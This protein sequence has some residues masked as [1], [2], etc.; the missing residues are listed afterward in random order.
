VSRVLITGANGHLGANTVRA[1]LNH[2]HEVVA[3][4]RPS[5]DVRGLAGL[6][7]RYAYG[8]VLDR[9]SLV[10]AASGAQAIIHS[11]A[12]FTYWSQDPDAVVRTGVTGIENVF[13]AAV[14]NGVSRVIYTSSTYA[15]GF[16]DD[17]D[18]PRGVDQWNEDAHSLYAISK[19]RAERAAWRLSDESGIPLISLCP[20]GMWGPYDYRITPAMRWIK[21]LVEGWLPVI[22]TAGS[23]VDVR[24]AA[25]IHARALSMGQPGQRYAIVASDL[26]HT[27]IASIVHELTGVRN[28]HLELGK[29]LTLL[30]AGLL[31]VAGRLTG[32][33]P[34]ATRGFVEEAYKRGLVADGRLANETFSVEPR[35]I[36]QS[37][38]DSI[39]WLMHIDA[40]WR[41]RAR[42]LQD[43]F[44]PDPSW[45]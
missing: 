11:A 42:R 5:A 36:R 15:I 34:I 16:S 1:L 21:A 29:R 35:P 7:I 45:P 14:E 39:S 19:V 6:D 30:A 31:E 41:W 9:E 17:M 37:I 25:E 10:T 3:F 27:D 24:D 13:A 38:R 12:V 2:G 43:R 18:S 26:R 23:F 4:V 20:S 40:I 28:L 33:E 32:W 22:D 44:P 8:D